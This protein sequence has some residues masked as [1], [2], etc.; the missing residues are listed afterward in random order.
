MAKAH[1]RLARAN[2]DVEQA[3]PTATN[4]G[5]LT[6]LTPTLDLDLMH[7]PA[8]VAVEEFVRDAFGERG[9]V[10]V[11]IGK[12]PKR[13]IPFRTSK[14]FKKITAPLRAPDGGDEKI[15]LLAD[16]QQVAVAGEHP[17]THKPYWWHGGTP[18]H[19]PRADLPYL[20]EDE[21]RAL[22]E[23]AVSIAHR[24]RVCAARAQRAPRAGQR[25]QRQRGDDRWQTLVDNI[26]AG[27]ALHDSFSDLAGML[28]VSGMHQGAAKPLLHA[29][30]EIIDRYDARVEARIRDIP[31]AIDSA[32]A[33]Y[34]RRDHAGILQHRRCP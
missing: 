7:E 31:R 30:A 24:L 9:H 11:R 25:R 32:V 5:V 19:V 23:N 27:R 4:T 14:P 1:R 12:P 22:V 16:G 2:Q 21:A 28:I 20:D 3:W 6:R 29:L 18:W 15:E 17:E 26:A 33:K 8:A 13:A 10:M 34:G